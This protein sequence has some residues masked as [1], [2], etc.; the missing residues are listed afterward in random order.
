MGSLSQADKLINY[1]VGTVGMDI[2]S[3]GAEAIR[4]E[5]EALIRQGVRIISIQRPPGLP[6]KAIVDPGPGGDGP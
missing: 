6:V 1:P 3:R 5:A 2:V 4:G